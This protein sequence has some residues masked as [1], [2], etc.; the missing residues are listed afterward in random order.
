MDKLVVF[1]LMT[2]PEVSETF[3]V[4]SIIGAIKSGYEVKIITN[5]L[6]DIS[7]SSQSSLI[8]A[9][10]LMDKVEVYKPT[11]V[12]KE[13]LLSFLTLIINPYLFYYFI[14]YVFIVGI[15]S[16]DPVFY[17]KF[18]KKYKSVSAF[19]VHFE[20]ALKP[21]LQ[22]KKI[23]YIKGKIIVTFHGYDAYYLPKQRRSRQSILNFEAY[24]NT[25]TVNSEYLKQVLINKGFTSD[26]IQIV[27]IGIDTDFFRLTSESKRY[28]NKPLQLIT[29]G[30]LIPLK[31]QLYGIK[32]VEAL[33]KKGCL[34]KYT[35]VGDGESLED[36]KAYVKANKLESYVIFT[37]NKNQTEVKELLSKSDVFLMTST[38]D[39][40]KRREAFG[41]V[42]LEAQALGVPIVGFDSGGFKDTIKNNTTGFLVADR[43]VQG[44]VARVELLSNDSAL[45]SRMSENAAE[46]VRSNFS[47]KSKTLSFTRYYS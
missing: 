10:H 34:V 33:I 25:I 45:L 23:G 47:L 9:Y 42:S 18:Y 26:L 22:L 20:P 19:H 17:L 3:V 36:L 14:K 21:L 32:A 12:K 2:F 43:D 29:V 15:K 39:H 38:Y 11:E 46:F 1:K 8:E 40:H 35:I 37:G 41:V 7:K 5:Q 4:N 16:L 28:K 30:R 24:V 27:P 6:N 44:L 13:R 31:G